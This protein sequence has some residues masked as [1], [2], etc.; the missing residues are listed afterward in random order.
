MWTTPLATRESGG[1]LLGHK[2]GERPHLSSKNPHG[3]TANPKTERQLGGRQQLEA[4][5]RA[6]MEG[7]KYG[8]PS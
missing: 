2:F 3:K 4:M 5:L 1:K 8:G 7:L 6:M